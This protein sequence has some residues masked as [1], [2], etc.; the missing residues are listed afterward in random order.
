MSII[1]FYDKTH[2]TLFS[3][4]SNAFISLSNH[5]NLVFKLSCG[6]QTHRTT[7][8]TSQAVLFPEPQCAPPSLR[9]GSFP[10]TG[11]SLMSAESL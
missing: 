5:C 1:H 7:V 9:C 6:I 2:K 3:W 8:I 4:G 10:K 11:D